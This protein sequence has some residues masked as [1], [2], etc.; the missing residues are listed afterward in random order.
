[1]PEHWYQTAILDVDHDTVSE[2]WEEQRERKQLI[3]TE[4]I[5][6]KCPYVDENS[7][8]VA[9]GYSVLVYVLRLR[10]RSHRCSIG[11]RQNYW[12]YRWRRWCPFSVQL[13]TQ[14]SRVPADLRT[15]SP[16][17]PRVRRA[18]L[19]HDMLPK[20]ASKGQTLPKM[21]PLRCNAR[22]SLPMA[23]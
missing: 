22:P 6:V 17:R 10:K 19:L 2:W 8:I 13:S 1:M 14:D 9:Q 7:K 23:W 18:P 15:I 11:W 4:G 5:W 16:I 20:P 3:L 12:L 21:Q